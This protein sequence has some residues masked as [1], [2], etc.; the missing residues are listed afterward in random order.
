VFYKKI[1]V[2]S[3]FSKQEYNGIIR[4]WQIDSFEGGKGSR[5]E[6]LSKR[7]LE[8]EKKNIGQLILVSVHTVQSAAAAF[9][10]GEYP[11]LISYGAGISDTVSLAYPLKNLNF[12]GGNISGENYAYPWCYGGYCIFSLDGEIDLNNLNGKKIVANSKGAIAAAALSGLNID[13]EL[14]EPVQAYI[15]FI[16]GKYDYLIGSQR[17]ICR[18][19]TRNL[20]FHLQP[21]N[22]YSDLYQYISILTNDSVKSAIA[23]KF[24]NYLLGEQSQKKLTSLSMMSFNYNIYT[25]DNEYMALLETSKISSTISAFM[26]EGKIAEFYSLADCAI[27][28]NEEALKKIKNILIYI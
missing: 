5:G 23:R 12:S 17:D 18:L 26:S 15:D 19:Q 1:T 20:N 13:Y 8:Y 21:L 28:G 16:N 11:D 22:Y 4:L 10:K 3:Y 25:S 7:A 24:I 2:D 6:F 14:K 27:K 9:K